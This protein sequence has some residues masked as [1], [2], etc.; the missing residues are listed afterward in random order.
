MKDYSEYV[1]IIKFKDKNPNKT[2]HSP[3]SITHIFRTVFLGST[4]LLL[5]C[6]LPFFSVPHTA[7]EKQKTSQDSPARRFFVYSQ[8]G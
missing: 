6:C 4:R 5:G 3:F 7:G 8:L 2:D 1:D